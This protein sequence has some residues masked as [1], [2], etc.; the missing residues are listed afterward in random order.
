[1]KILILIVSFITIN[2][3][4]QTPSLQWAVT[5]GGPSSDLGQSVVVDAGGYIY[6]TGYYEGTVDFDPG[7]NVNNLTALGSYDIFVS[8]F[9]ASGN[10][11]WVKSMGGPSWDNGF[12]IAVDISG[13]VY[14]TG[15]FSGTADF[16][17][18]S[19]VINLTSAG[20]YDIFV[21]KLDTYG[22]YLWAKKMGGTLTD[23]ALA[24]T[25]DAS[26]NVYTTGTFLGTADFDPSATTVNLN[27]VGADD[28]FI[29]KLD[30][31][32]NYVFAKRMGG[33]QT[34]VAYSIT[35]DALGNIYTTGD[36]Y[37]TADFDP[38]ISIANLTSVGAN[39]IFI[40]KL[41]SNGN[42]VWA[43][44]MGG[45]SPENSR[46]IV[47]D[48][49]GNIYT[50]GS[51][52]GAT[53]FD[54]NG[55]IANL[56][57]NGSYDIFVSKLDSSGNF[58][59]AKNMG[60]VSADFGFSIAVDGVSN[61]YTTGTIAGTADFDPNI[62]I[63]NLTSNG[64]DDIFISKLNSLGNF[65]WAISMGDTARDV[66][67]SISVDG[68]NNVYTAGWY[69]GTVDFDPSASALHLTSVGSNDIYVNKLNQSTTTIKENDIKNSFII[70]PNPTSDQFFIVAN[71]TDKLV[72]DMYDVNGRHVFSKSVSDKSNIDVTTLI[73]G[74]YN[75]TIKTV[76]RVINKKLVILR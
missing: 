58:I 43:K 38:S 30:S 32:G 9:D 41:N 71:T 14:S 25:I 7:I 37:G 75:L 55:G 64:G 4:A 45:A 40:S 42:F 65:S 16:D 35:V 63:I 17:P 18:N 60:G 59:W 27:S 6:T 46:S 76:D 73:E 12:S 31:A 1:M 52:Y 47:V 48:A 5:M 23:N 49:S 56:V 33:S 24:L 50:T 61:V 29:S 19:N 44:S 28:I 53:D 22:N 72:V 21:L 67:Y 66:G 20:S 69:N 36:F 13:N 3:K 68:I 39:D 26:C 2:L 8:K 62:G 51:F 34:D 11:I 54:P 57:S 15:V 10:L 74:I 70:Y